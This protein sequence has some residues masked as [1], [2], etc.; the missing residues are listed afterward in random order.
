MENSNSLSSQIALAGQ[1]VEAKG[2]LYEQLMTDTF[3]KSTEL[4]DE[5]LECNYSLISYVPIHQN[6]FDAANRLKR[7]KGADCIAK[8]RHVYWNK[9]N[10]LALGFLPHKQGLLFLAIFLSMHPIHSGIRV[11]FGNDDN[12]IDLPES[13]WDAEHTED[14][15]KAL[16]ALLNRGVVGLI[17]S[18]SSIEMITAEAYRFYEDGAI[19]LMDV[20]EESS[21]PSPKPKSPIGFVRGV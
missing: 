11:Y 5:L 16:T 9:G 17:A 12:T 3:R 1:Q 6:P 4:A 2:K 20:P 7:V 19:K 14:S 21:P 15:L 18:L 8:I 10:R 13:A